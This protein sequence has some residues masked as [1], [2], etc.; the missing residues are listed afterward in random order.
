MKKV[1]VIQIEPLV[2]EYRG[3]V[4]AIARKLGVN[5]STIWARVKES[6][7]LQES[8]DNARQTMLDDAEDT[9]Y[10]KALAGDIT[11]LIF[12]L[13]TQGKNR[14]YTERYEHGG[15]GGEPIQI[16]E[17]IIGGA[18]QASRKQAT[19]AV[20]DEPSEG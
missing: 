16:S 13:K 14:G 1:T 11:A 9:L 8:L 2:E 4:A 7:T 10:S 5:R 17:V 6:K 20:L 19:G 3:N 15:I 18:S 12:F